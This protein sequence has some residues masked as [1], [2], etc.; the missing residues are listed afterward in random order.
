MADTSGAGK[1]D[2]RDIQY[3]SKPSP[4]Q[5]DWSTTVNDTFATLHNISLGCEVCLGRKTL[6]ANETVPSTG[7]E[8]FSVASGDAYMAFV[9]RIILVGL[10]SGDTTNQS[11]WKFGRGGT[12]AFADW[13]SNRTVNF[14]TAS[15][16]SGVIIYADNSFSSGTTG[17]DLNMTL[18]TGV[19]PCESF[20]VISTSGVRCDS[21]TVCG[22]LIPYS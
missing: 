15:E 16:R 1:L 17:D 8:L 21:I 3:L 5:Y 9:K 12:G 2:W 13:A 10:D 11:G 14:G 19:A 18:G 7:M 22:F 6:A 20:G 4:G